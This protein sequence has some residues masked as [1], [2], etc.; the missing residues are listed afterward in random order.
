[1]ANRTGFAITGSR[2]FHVTFKSGVTVSVQFGVANYCE[3][4]HGDFSMVGKEK[5]QRHWESID[6][7]VALWDE[8]GTF[9]TKQYFDD[10]EVHGWL[11]PDELP[12]LLAWAANYKE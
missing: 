5:E 8:E 4:H 1:M 9:I 11:M 6:A 10:D 7:E 12:A 2:G 3:H